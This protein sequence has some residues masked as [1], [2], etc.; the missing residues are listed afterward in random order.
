MGKMID[1]AD[2]RRDRGTKP[3]MLYA[4]PAKILPYE[5]R[6]KND[7]PFLFVARKHSPEPPVSEGG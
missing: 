4:E 5:K 2:V 6:G 3:R 7:A 1:L